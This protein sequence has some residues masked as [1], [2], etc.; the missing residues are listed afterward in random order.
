VSDRSIEE[1]YLNYAEARGVLL[2]AAAKRIPLASLA[3][4]AR[5]LSLWRHNRVEPGSEAQ[6]ACVM[7]LGVFSPVGGHKPAL[8]RLVNAATPPPGSPDE[9]MLRAFTRARFSLFRVGERDPR[10]GIALHDLC[11]G[12]RVWLMDRHLAQF[13]LA[14]TLIGARLAWPEEFALTCGVIVPVD[15]RVLL[16]L[17]ENR[18]PLTGPVPAPIEPRPNDPL[19]AQLLAEEIAPAR[20][21]ELGHDPLLAVN[22]YRAALDHGL[23]GPVPGR[24]G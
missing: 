6:F 3:A 14:E 8:E 16:A 21:E 19:I 7:D 11:T 4:Q 15:P 23:L 5:A 2:N 24:Q 12:E 18:A 17:M 13:G 22:T 10:G 20:L 9:A 1:R